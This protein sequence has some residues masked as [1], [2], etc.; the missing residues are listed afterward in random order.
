MNDRSSISLN[1]VCDEE[2]QGVSILVVRVV[3]NFVVVFDK[4]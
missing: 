4:Y 1:A 3:H 2:T